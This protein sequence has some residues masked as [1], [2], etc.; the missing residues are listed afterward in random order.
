MLS[1]KYV[2]ICSYCRDTN[3]AFQPCA[4][5]NSTAEPAILNGGLTVSSPV[6]AG[7]VHNLHA[8]HIAG[9]MHNLHAEHIISLACLLCA[10]PSTML[11]VFCHFSA[12]YSNISVIFEIIEC[13]SACSPSSSCN[14]CS[15]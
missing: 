12:M 14:Q 3:G 10:H 2:C 15:T 1:T 5:T 4:T 9:A 6:V 7:E 8:E 13:C 11:P